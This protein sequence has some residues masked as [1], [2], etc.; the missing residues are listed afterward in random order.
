MDLRFG[1]GSL[2]VGAQ[3]DRLRHNCHGNPKGRSNGKKS[4]AARR[5][6]SAYDADNGGPCASNFK[7]FAA[8]RR[9]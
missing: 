5:E 7:S 8:D 9:A 6:A 3:V 1:F 2:A 4:K